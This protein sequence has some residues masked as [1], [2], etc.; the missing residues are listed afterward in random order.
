M[1]DDARR[2]DCAESLLGVQIRIPG[3]DR[4]RHHSPGGT[5]LFRRDAD[6]ALLGRTEHGEWNGND[7][8]SSIAG[9]GG[10]GLPGASRDQ[11]GSILDCVSETRL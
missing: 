3:S 1:A 5:P 8:Q 9:D 4:V 7:S 2:R 10:V 11:V 6:E